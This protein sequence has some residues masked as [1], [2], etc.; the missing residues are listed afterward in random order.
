MES[1]A[2]LAPSQR[3]ELFAETAVR[4]GM[5]PAIMKKG[6]WVSWTLETEI[7]GLHRG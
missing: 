1:V 7:N 2:A 6:L 5:T 4:K 3:R